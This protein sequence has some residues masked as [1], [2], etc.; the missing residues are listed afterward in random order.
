MSYDL[1]INLY[2]GGRVVDRVKSYCA[3]RKISAVRDNKGVMRMQLN[4]K[5]LFHLGLLDQ[6]WFPNGL[7]IASGGNFYHTG[8]VLDQHHYPE[9]KMFL[10]D[11]DRVNVLG[12]YGGIGYA[13]EGSLWQANENF[14]YDAPL[15]NPEE[16]AGKYIEYLNRLKSFNRFSGAVYTQITD[17]EGEINRRTNLRSRNHF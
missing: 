4:N 16:S 13:V 1:E 14:G 17:V 15:K 11:A 8:D 10:Y 5:N 12:E 2:S 3:M 9:P 6:G 7:Y